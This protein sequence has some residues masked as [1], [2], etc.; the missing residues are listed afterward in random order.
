MN[1]NST[2][3]AL[4]KLSQ[5]YE[6]HFCYK[7]IHLTWR[8]NPVALHALP[9][10][11]SVLYIL[12][13][14]YLPGYLIAR[15]INLAD[16]IKPWMAGWNL[17]LSLLSLGMFFGIGIPN[18]YF[19][20]EYG[21]AALCNPNGTVVPQT[22]TFIYWIAMFG[23]MKYFELVDTFFLIVKKPEREVPFLHW[24][25][26]FTVLYFTWYAE[27]WRLPIGLVFATVNSLVHAFMYWYYFQTELGYSPWWAKPLTVG[28]IAQ[29]LLGLALNAYWLNGYLTGQGCYC[30]NAQILIAMGVTIYAS[31]LFLFSKY[32]VQRY[33]IKPKKE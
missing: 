8:F 30:E 3:A 7:E 9:F 19:I 31:Y 14:N 28:Q 18:F 4:E 1:A 13:I 17:F 26:H 23:Y 24:Y 10:V 22:G 21:T 32:F 16:K 6:D 20:Y 25:H 33:L 29:M 15:K 11:F 2:F 12:M 27:N 5:F